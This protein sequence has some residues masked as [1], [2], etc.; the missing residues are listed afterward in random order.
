M[1]CMPEAGTWQVEAVHLDRG[2]GARTWFAVR[3]G[4]TATYPASAADADEYLA[5][6]GVSVGDLV[7]S[8]VCPALPWEGVPSPGETDGTGS[9]C[10]VA[11]CATAGRIGSRAAR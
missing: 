8:G 11:P 7:V 5:A 2:T 3:T 4:D 9:A 6:H 10:R 1:E